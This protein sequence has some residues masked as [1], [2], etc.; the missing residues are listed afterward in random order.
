[1]IPLFIVADEVFP[2]PLLFIGYD[3]RKLVNLKF[4]ILRRVR[5]VE[6]PLLKR[7][8]STDKV[9]KPTILFIE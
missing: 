8:V 1:M 9:H 2:I 5:I 4:L 6:S 3:F 7:D